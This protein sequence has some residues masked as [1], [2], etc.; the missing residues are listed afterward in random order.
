MEKS[1]LNPFSINYKMKAILPTGSV[2]TI[3][4]GQLI[5]SIATNYSV[6]SAF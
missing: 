3:N 1:I 4:R 6:T 2:G 5:V